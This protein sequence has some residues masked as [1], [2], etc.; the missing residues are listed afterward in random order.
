MILCNQVFFCVD[1]C[2]VL[3]VYGRTVAKDSRCREIWSVKL[4]NSIGNSEYNDMG[5]GGEIN[6]L[7]FW[8]KFEIIEFLLGVISRIH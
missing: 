2:S 1:F 4:W 6:V 7:N 5:R 8:G 3:Y